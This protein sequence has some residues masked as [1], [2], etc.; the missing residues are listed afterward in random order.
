[1]SAGRFKYLLSKYLNDSLS[2]KEK[3][4][5]FGMV[6]TGEFD[7]QLGADFEDNFYEEATDEDNK[8]TVEEDAFVQPTEEELARVISLRRR[9]I[10]RILLQSAAA[11]LLFMSVGLYVYFGNKPQDNTKAFFTQFIK[12]NQQQVK[13][14]TNTEMAVVLPDKSVITLQPASSLY[15]STNNFGNKREVYMEG[16]ALFNITKN[17]KSPF[18][19][20]YKDVV[21][22]V[23]GTSFNIYTS[24]KTGNTEVEVLTGKVQVY[25]NEKIYTADKKVSN[26]VIVTPNQK[27]VYENVNHTFSATLTDDPKP[28]VSEEKLSSKKLLANDSFN[29]N[30]TELAEVFKNIELNYGIKITVS[31]EQIYAY[32]FSGDITSQGVF[33]KL[34]IISLAT[35]TQYEVK[36]TTILISDVQQ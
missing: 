26:A 30:N 24:S 21:T 23:L 18:Y 2:F 15:Y 35:H 27:A 31:N 14:S 10:T 6:E 19:V 12:T 33:D 25:G 34:K 36:G 22:K 3:K 13:N 8:A 9:K 4:E 5:F 32:G 1:M 20:Y 11:V 17:P 28:I 16:R 7:N 29:F